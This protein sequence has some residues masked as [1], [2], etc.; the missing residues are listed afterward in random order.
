MAGH[1]IDAGVRAAA[2][3]VTSDAA[4]HAGAPLKGD[5]R[6]GDRHR[7]L[8]HV[9]MA[10][11][12]V[13]VADRDVATMAEQRVI[14]EPRNLLPGEF[15][16]GLEERHQLGF[17][18]RVRLRRRVTGETEIVGW[19]T[20]SLPALSSFVTVLALDAQLFGVDLVV[21]LN[22]LCIALFGRRAGNSPD[23][24]RNDN[25]RGAEKNPPRWTAPRSAPALTR[26]SPRRGVALSCHRRSLGFLT[27]TMDPPSRFVAG[28]S[29]TAS[30]QFPALTAK[31]E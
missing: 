4:Q 18:G 28:G 19:K 15:R 21:V 30:R 12:A 23:G 6:F 3:D 27:V 10:G 31:Q 26:G 7:P 20:G 1:A 14:R 17:F 2:L 13:D 11:D 9:A 5:G 29:G 24:E 16:S 22:R 8:A 25:R